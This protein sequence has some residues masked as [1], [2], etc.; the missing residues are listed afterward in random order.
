MKPRIA[1]EDRSPTMHSYYK[2]HEARKAAKR[3]Q[4]KLAY[5]ANPE[6]ARKIKY[7]WRD[8]NKEKVRESSARSYRKNKI[9]RLAYNK[10]YYAANRAR[11]LIQMAIYRLNHPDEIRAS[12]RQYYL[13]NFSYFQ[14]YNKQ[15]KLANKRTIRIIE[16]RR[17][18]RKHALPCTFT[19]EDARFML[20]YWGFACAVCGNQDGFAWKISL[21][22]WIP[23]ASP[24]CPGT[25]ATNMVPLCSGIGGCNNSKHKRDPH[26][27]LVQRYGRRKA[28]SIEKKVRAYFAIVKARQEVTSEAAD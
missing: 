1:E 8:K 6:R 13:D 3:L 2:H 5:A 18:S 22:H 16:H 23:V 27:W 20:E 28:A 21:D 17:R 12:L 15:Y 9:K 26:E 4:A 14:A 25:V 24:A 11:L 7:A 10:R 19:R